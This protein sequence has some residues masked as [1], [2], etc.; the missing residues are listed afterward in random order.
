MEVLV[1]HCQHLHKSVAEAKVDQFFITF[2]PTLSACFLDRGMSR[3][4]ID[5]SQFANTAQAHSSH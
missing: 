2:P 1:R 5:L 3:G 4:L